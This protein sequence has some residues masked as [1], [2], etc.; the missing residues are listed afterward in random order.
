MRIIT[1]NLLLVGA[2]AVPS[3]GLAQSSASPAP[4]PKATA[5]RHVTATHAARGVVQS[6]DANTLVIKRSGK[7]S[8]EMTFALNNSTQRS[9]SI[10]VGT[11]VSVRY[12]KEGKSATATAIT[13][14]Q[15]AKATQKPAARSNATHKG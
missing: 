11:P 14:E 7:K 13:A 12:Q 15:Q 10:A 5:G 8:S 3:I 4:K 9:G 1:A 6:M 2:L